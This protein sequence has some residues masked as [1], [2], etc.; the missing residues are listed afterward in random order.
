MKVFFLG[1][2]FNIETSLV[3]TLN[4]LGLLFFS[5]AIVTVC[6]SKS[7]S[8]HLSL[9][10]SPGRPAVSLIV[11]RNVVV[12]PPR[13]AINWSNSDSEGMKGNRSILW[14]L[15]GLKGRLFCLQKPP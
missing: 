10:T 5:W 15:G 8:N 2:R 14:H 12:L 1:R 11:W 4:C 7:R 6:P 9:Q 3:E 13:P